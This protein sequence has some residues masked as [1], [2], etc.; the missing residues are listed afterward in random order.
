[1][2]RV[3]R[4]LNVQRGWRRL[5]VGW[6]FFAPLF[7]DAGFLWS[8]WGNLDDQ[9]TVPT[10]SVLV[11]V[12][13]ALVAGIPLVAVLVRLQTRRR[14]SRPWEPGF[15]WRL[16]AAMYVF[17]AGAGAESYGETRTWVWRH[18]H[19]PFK[20]LI[21]SNAVACVLGIWN[22]RYYRKLRRQAEADAQ[23]AANWHS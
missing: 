9:A 15:S 6:L 13:I 14:K 7:V 1:V 22:A 21:L 11:R 19:L 20:A 23:A 5:L 17:M 4:W 18:Q 8:G 2:D 12:V 3:D 10:G 16:F